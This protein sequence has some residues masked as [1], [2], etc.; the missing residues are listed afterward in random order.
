MCV[1]FS[2]AAEVGESYACHSYLGLGFGSLI[3]SLHCTR[4]PGVRNGLKGSTYLDRLAVSLHSIG[5]EWV[6][7]LDLRRHHTLLI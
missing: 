7:N 4:R 2:T 5:I 1:F 6:R 3:S